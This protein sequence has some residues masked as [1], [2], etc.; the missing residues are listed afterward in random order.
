MGVPRVRT[1]ADD[2]ERPL[3]TEGSPKSIGT[4]VTDEMS[5][6]EIGNTE[7]RSAV[8]RMD[9]KRLLIVTFSVAV[10]FGMGVVAICT[11]KLLL[12]DVP[13]LLL[14]LQQFTL[15]STLLRIVLRIKD[16][17]ARPWPWKETQTKVHSSPNME[18]ILAGLFNGLD[19]LASANAF[20]SAP[21]SFVETIKSSDPITTTAV[22]L[23][24]GMDSIQ[25]RVESFSL[26]L[27]L[28]GVMLSTLGNQNDSSSTALEASVTLADSIASALTVIGANLCFAFRAINQKR[29]QRDSPNPMDDVNLLC[30]MQQTAAIALLPIGAFMYGVTI[31][32]AI[33]ETPF[34]VQLAYA[35]LALTNAVGFVSYNL[36]ACWVLTQVSM[37]TYSGLNCVRRMFCIL[38]TS[39]FFGIPMTL[40]SGL[41]VGACFAGFGLFTHERRRRTPVKT[42]VETK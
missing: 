33:W 22:A 9:T 18:F 21:P 11:T 17:G 35:K 36:A 29:Y 6:I 13:P 26:L 32:S 8:P 38:G 3:V 12:A 34:N 14:T 27:L 16:G 41:G 20:H 19:F 37:L 4:T 10:W 30:R 40:T 1:H 25:S 2:E 24:F 39:I 31:H 42:E 28:I 7:I 5:D 15:S 23:L